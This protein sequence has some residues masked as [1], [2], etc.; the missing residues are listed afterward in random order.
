MIVKFTLQQ[1][2]LLQALRHSPSTRI[3]WEQTDVTDNDERL[4]LFWA[5][6]EDYEAFEA[7][8]YEDPTVTAPRHLTEFSDRRL[9]QVEQIG[10]GRAQ[11]VYPA[12][13][14]AGGVV[15]ELTADRDGWHFQVVFPDHEALSHFHDVCNEHDLPFSLVQ[16]YERSDDREVS[17]DFGLTE[18]QREMLVSAVEYGYFEVPRGT[19]LRVLADEM[20]I[21][22][23]AASERLRRAVDLL[24][25]RSLGLT[26]DDSLPEAE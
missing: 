18:K 1:P 21:S 10:E 25:R 7:G 9:Y 16:K 14:E 26:D 20:G 15:Q 8:M 22:H 6:S 23:Q 12:L 5:E 11:S 13:V 17:D 2:T 24:V 3:V 4:L 19:D